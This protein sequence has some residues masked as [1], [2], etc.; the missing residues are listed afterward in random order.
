[1]NLFLSGFIFVSVYN[2]LNTRTNDMSLT[3][4]WSLFISYLIKLFYSL[5]HI[6]LLKNTLINSNIKILVYSATGFFLAVILTYIKKTGYLQKLF[7]NIN[8]KS[9][10]DNIFD[11]IIDYEKQTRMNIFLKSS[12][13]YY[14]GRFAMREEKDLDSWI[15][16]T[17]YCRINKE[18]INVIFDPDDEGLKS[19]VAIN[20][21]NIEYIEIMYENDSNVWK[22]INFETDI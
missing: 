14:S 17:D 5:I 22:R 3:I 8:N 9:I 11:D 18:T 19:T 12:N 1:M 10:N 7:Y 16:L 20:L 2:C 4:I 15:I 13:I 21:H 6:I